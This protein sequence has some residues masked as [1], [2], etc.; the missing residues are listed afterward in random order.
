VTV[1]L[2]GDIPGPGDKNIS[3]NT[4]LKGKILPVYKKMVL[5][6]HGR[7]SAEQGYE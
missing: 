7:S 5:R 6:P 1:N 2:P 3:N 4:T